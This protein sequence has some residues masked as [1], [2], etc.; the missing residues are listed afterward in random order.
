MA[1]RAVVEAIH[2]IVNLCHV[3]HLSGVSIKERIAWIKGHHRLI[4]SSGC[5]DWPAFNKLFKYFFQM[6][7]LVYFGSTLINE[8]NKQLT[9][10]RW[11]QIWNKNYQ[12]GQVNWLCY[13][14]LQSNVKV[15]PACLR[16]SLIRFVFGPCRIGLAF[17]TFGLTI[18]QCIVRS[19]CSSQPFL[20]LKK[21]NLLDFGLYEF[22]CYRD[23]SH[24]FPTAP[25]KIWVVLKTISSFI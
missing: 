20:P 12:D 21:K 10:I 8:H 7:K 6:L 4:V 13:S 16:I 3:V 5:K 25:V 18:S 1:K 11:V 2:A 24:L 14:D 17:Q 9:L 23:I 15:S 19:E 22:E